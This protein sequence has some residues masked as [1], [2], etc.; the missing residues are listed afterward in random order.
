MRM[1]KTCGL[2]A[3]GRMWLN[4]TLFAK[5]KERGFPAFLDGDRRSTPLNA[6]P[7]IASLDEL[8]VR[9]G[10]E[11]RSIL[12][13]NLRIGL[14]E[15]EEIGLH[16]LAILIGGSFLDQRKDPGDLDCIVFYATGLEPN[17]TVGSDWQIKQRARG[18]DARLVPLDSDPIVLLKSA[19]FFGALY[20]RPTGEHES[21]RGLVLVD[22][23]K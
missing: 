2:G 16:A 20:S 17:L 13:R 14:M 5:A 23:Q 6:T 1:D 18:I 12:L 4:D 7:Y 19:L 22:C 11:K 21:T 15:L 8:D 9:D 3:N 10:S